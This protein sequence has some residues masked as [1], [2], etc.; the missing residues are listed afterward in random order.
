MPSTNIYCINAQLTTRSADNCTRDM[1]A[2]LIF[3]VITFQYY[4]IVS[5]L[6]TSSCH[7]HFFSH[8]LVLCSTV[9]SYAHIRIINN[10]QRFREFL[11]KWYDNGNN[12]SQSPF[13][14]SVNLLSIC[15]CVWTDHPMK[16]SICGQ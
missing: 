3:N 8:N 13:S 4:F 10:I 12:Y 6:N 14:F 16:L 11:S 9:M 2:V 15:S 5:K 1:I 7:T